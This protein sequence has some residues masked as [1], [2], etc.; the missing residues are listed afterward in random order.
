MVFAILTFIIY[1][2]NNVIVK[3]I[4]ITTI[5]IITITIIASE[6]QFLEIS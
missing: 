1:L 6:R 4:T 2:N 5:T 3:I